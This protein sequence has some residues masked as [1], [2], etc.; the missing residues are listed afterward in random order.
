MGSFSALRGI[1]STSKGDRSLGDVQTPPTE[2]EVEV[3]CNRRPE[4]GPA[5]TPASCHSRGKRSGRIRHFEEENAVGARSA[6]RSAG[7][8][9]PWRPKGRP[10]VGMGQNDRFGGQPSQPRATWDGAQATGRSK[11]RG[12]AGNLRSRSRR[13]RAVLPTGIVDLHHVKPHSLAHDG[14]LG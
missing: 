9:G 4:S 2:S 11:A 13:A 12:A 6:R 1:S 14:R 5:S 8:G 10:I 3:V 7:V